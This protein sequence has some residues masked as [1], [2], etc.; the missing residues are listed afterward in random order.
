MGRTY[1]IPTP[2]NGIYL[3][4][5]IAHAMVSLGRS[6]RRPPESIRS[7]SHSCCGPVTEEHADM[8]RGASRLPARRQWAIGTRGV[9]YCDFHTASDAAACTAGQTRGCLVL[10]PCRPSGRARNPTLGSTGQN[11]SPLDPLQCVFIAFLGIATW[12]DLVLRL[13]TG[14]MSC[15]AL[16]TLSLSKSTA[17]PRRNMGFWPFAHLPSRC[18]PYRVAHPS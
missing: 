10:V 12:C 3:D 14:G 13:M 5:L 15:A 9:G 4:I 18:L 17:Q 6:L 7:A 2:S 8:G 16:A 11:V 1:P